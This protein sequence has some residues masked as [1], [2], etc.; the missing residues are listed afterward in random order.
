[1]A[2]NTS[3]GLPPNRLDPP[4]VEVGTEGLGKWMVKGWE[5]QRL[6]AAGMVEQGVEKPIGPPAMRLGLGDSGRGWD[7]AG[8]RRGRG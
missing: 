1:M 6:G 2:L 8:R 5:G 7:G 4:P 3:P